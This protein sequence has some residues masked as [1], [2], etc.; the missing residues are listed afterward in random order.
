M[1]SF[2]LIYIFLVVCCSEVVAQDTVAFFNY[3]MNPDYFS[4]EHDSVTGQYIF[5]CNYEGGDVVER[6]IIVDSTLTIATETA[7]FLN[8]KP[9]YTITSNT[10]AN[11]EGPFVEYYY[12]GNIKRKGKY[13]KDFRTGEWIEYFDDGTK[14]SQGSYQMSKRDSINSCA[15][16]NDP[17]PPMKKQI[18]F[19]TIRYG[20]DNIYINKFDMNENGVNKT[21]TLFITQVRT[22]YLPPK[23]GVWKYWRMNG[24]LRLEEEFKNG[25]LIRRKKYN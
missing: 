25:I 14:K 3:Y 7:Y 15:F 19:D 13:F 24:D 9:V 4:H 8:G 1:K 6:I 22:T 5:R 17:T 18:Y 2:C 11:F 23:N 21:D 12:N 16:S 10:N 20:Q